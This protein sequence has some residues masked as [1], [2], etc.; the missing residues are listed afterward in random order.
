MT[1]LISVVAY[2][3]HQTLFSRELTS[4]EG[5]LEIQYEE[6]DSENNY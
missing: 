3:H 2:L 4:I 6:L 1:I 5:T